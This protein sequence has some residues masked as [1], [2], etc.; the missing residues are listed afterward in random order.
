[1]SRAEVG[2]SFGSN[3]GDRQAN[4]SHALKQVLVL[5]GVSFLDKSSL[6]ETDPVQVSPAHQHKLFLNSVAIIE[7]ASTPILLL[8]ALQLIEKKLGRQ[9]A[10]EFNAPR[11]VDIDIIYIGSLL[12][13][14]RQLTLPHPRWMERR[15]VVQPLAD[16]RPNLILPG[17]SL[18]VLEILFALPSDPVVIEFHNEW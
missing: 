16:V 5:P 6:Y 15:F 4:L 7:I 9:P 8:E 12:S 14:D 17:Q 3:L 1:M 11:P 2:L 18:S 10:T 13:G